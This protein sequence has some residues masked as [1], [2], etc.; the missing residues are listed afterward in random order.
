MT[1]NADKSNVE[2]Y[3]PMAGKIVGLPVKVGQE[4]KVG[5]A[6]LRRGSWKGATATVPPRLLPSRLRLRPQATCSG[7]PADRAPR[8][9]P[10]H[11]GQG[12]PCGDLRRQ[13]PPPHLDNGRRASSRRALA[14]RLA[15]LPPR[16][17]L[18]LSKVQPTGPNNRILEEDVKAAQSPG[19]VVVGGV[20]CMQLEARRAPDAGLRETGSARCCEPLLQPRSQAHRPE[21]EPCVDG[22]PAR[23]AERH[24]R[25]HRPRG[26]PQAAGRHRDQ[27][28]KQDLT[29]RRSRVDLPGLRAM[30]GKKAC[31]S[32][33]AGA[34][35]D[36]QQFA[37]PG[38]QPARP[39]GV[40]PR[41]RRR[42]YQ[43]RPARPRHPRRGQEEHRATGMAS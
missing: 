13:R 25:H 15:G 17:G 27:A 9:T 43:G 29:V 37:R 40:L 28:G 21:D 22:H 41:R 3:S 35:P 2:I 14:T 39:Q 42:R 34:V 11:R 1:V 12:D 23:H 18:D 4:I 6:V 31:A 26:V 32:S 10:A 36:V 16:L 24:R 33:R 19:T 5:R 38:E 8:R 30:G 7:N 20:G